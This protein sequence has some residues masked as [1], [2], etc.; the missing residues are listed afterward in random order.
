LDYRKY[1]RYAGLGVIICLAMLSQCLAD[2]V[3]VFNEIMYNPAEDFNDTLEWVELYNQMS[4]NIDLSHWS[5]KGGVKY[6]FPE[7]AIIPADGFVVVALSP[8]DL[9]SRTGYGQAYGPFEGRLSN[10]GEELRLHNNS[11]RMMNSVEYGNEGDWP[12]AADGS[13]VS[14]AKRDPQRGSSA[15][16]NWTWSRQV[17]GTPGRHNFPASQELIEVP[18]LQSGAPARAMVPTNDSLGTT[19]I[20]KDFIDSGWLSGATGVGYEAG[21]GYED[22]IN[23]DVLTQMSGQYPSC[24][25]RVPFYVEDASAVESLSLWMKYDDGF[26][27]Y[28]NGHEVARVN[29]TGLLYWNST[30]DQ[31][32]VEGSAADIDISDYIDSLQDGWNILAIHGLNQAAGSTDFLILPELTAYLSDSADELDRFEGLALNEVASAAAAAGEFQVELYNGGVRTM[33]LAGCV[34]RCAGAVTGEYV[35]GNSSME[36]GDYVVVSEAQLGFRPADEDRLFLYTPDGNSVIDAAVVKNS[37]RGRHPEGSGRWLY[38]DLKTFG[39]ANSFSFHDEIVIN[40]IMYHQRGTAGPNDSYEE[41]RE[42]WLELYNRSDRAVVLTGWEIDGGIEYA[43]PQG[44]TIEPDGYLVVADDATYLR[45]LYPDIDIVGSFSGGLSSR[46]DLIILKDASRNPADE[47]HYYERAPWPEYSDGYGSSLELK[48]PYADNSRPEAWAA[49]DESGKSQWQTVVYRGIA[50]QVY[51]PNPWWSNYHNDYIYW[52]EFRAGLLD[53]GEVLLDDVSVIENPGGAARQLIQNGSF[54]EGRGPYGP[55]HWRIVGNHRHSELI[56]DPDNP[57]NHVLHLKA[58]GRMEPYDNHAETTLKYDGQ[59]IPVEDGKEYEISFRARWLTGSNQLNTRLYFSRLALTTLLEVPAKTGTPGAR[60]SRYEGNIGPTFS[61]FGHS[62]VVPKM[63]QP[64]N[65]SVR[66]SDPDGIN[67]CVLVWRVDGGPW[68]N[69]TMSLDGNGL[70]GA[71]IPGQG[72]STI[73]QFYVA[74]QDGQGT[75][76]YYPSKGHE[77]RALYKVDDGQASSGP[78][79]NLRLILT[80]ADLA[81]MYEPVHVHSDER[82]GATLIYDEREAFYDIGV[83]L[84]GAG[85]SRGVSVGCYNI[86]LDYGH[87]FRDVHRTLKIDRYQGLEEISVKHMFN[88]GRTPCMYD[89][90][91]HFIGPRGDQIGAGIMVM[92]KYEDVFLETQ[93]PNGDKGTAFNLDLT[94]YPIDTQDHG[95]ESLK[96]NAQPQPGLLTQTDLRNLGDDK[97]NYR[98]PLQIKNN[99]RQ[100]DYSGLIAFC[101]TLSLPS[102]ELEA[103]ISKVMDVDEWMRYTAITYLCGIADTYIK[104]LP[105]NMWVYVGLDGKARALPWDMDFTFWHSPTDHPIN[106]LT[107]NN[108]RRV[109][110]L[111]GSRRLYYGHLRDLI[112]TTFNVPYMTYWMQHFDRLL[113]GCNFIADLN[114]I[115]TRSDY[116]L[117][118]LPQIQEAFE[119]R[120]LDPN[121]TVAENYAEITGKAWIDVREIYLQGQP[122]PLELTWTSTSSG[123]TERFYWHTTVPLEPGENVLTFNAYGF[124]GEFIGSDTVTITSTVTEQPLRDYLRLTELMYDPLED[125]DYEFIE[126]LNT[127]PN[128]LDLSEVTISDAVDFSFA[129]SGV[130]SLGPGQYVVIVR[131]LS[132]FSSRYDTSGMLIADGYSGKLANDGERIRIT[133]KWNAEILNFQYS[134]GRLWPLAADGSGHSLVPVETAMA[135][136]PGGLLN[137]PGNWRAS[138]FIHGSPGRADP[139]LPKVVVLNEI[140]A[141]TDSNDPNNGSN[142]WIELY[143]PTT[144]PVTLLAGEWYLSDDR[145][146]LDK[147]AMPHTVIPAKECVSFDEETGFHNPPTVGFGLA[148]AGE[149]V[150]LSYLP[151]SGPQRG[152]IDSVRFEGQESSVSL[153]RYPDAGN[154]WFAMS[155]TRDGNNA[156]PYGHVVIEEI[157]YHPVDPAPE[158]IQLYNPT[159]EAVTLSNDNGGWQLRDGVEYTFDE[160]ISLAPGGRLIVVGFDP[161]VQTEL[162]SFE[163]TYAVR[164]LTAGEDIVGPWTGNLSNGGERLSLEKPQEPDVV[165]QPTIWVIVDEVIYSDRSPWPGDADGTGCPLQRISSEAE[166]AGNDPDNW[167]AA[168][169]ALDKYWV[170]PGDFDNNGVV[171]LRD[172]STLAAAWQSED[173]QGNWNELCDISQSADGVI[174]SRDLSVYAIYW[175]WVSPSSE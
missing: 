108:L 121:Y 69:E 157:M 59:I 81:Y 46:S 4:C 73:V 21:S 34:L 95:L 113:P 8:N 158:Y 72:S 146:Q 14:L 85:Y 114:Y 148:K 117:T 31:P 172:F 19:W 97:E 62:P 90:L 137:Y 80:A 100:D 63:N 66:A 42:A 38:P 169:V 119:V 9:Q 15:P 16:E 101:Q 136:Q 54:E 130:T 94:Y 167:E 154:Y 61:D 171:D 84:K 32:C 133:G 36:P 135:D 60:N 170:A 47:V 30:S 51:G 10:G 106:S 103:Q 12:V 112:N 143:N 87:R 57:N 23:L 153:G 156:E 43:F 93:W 28:I 141:H 68:H 13:G 11:G 138:T 18:V 151:G 107:Y 162:D 159:N 129:G 164:E 175:L 27:A 55:R 26:A 83:R 82:L 98:W 39:S 79:H 104:G 74:A 110:G 45:Q 2:S 99:R 53:S 88:R 96:T 123:S 134:D 3:V 52:N 115:Q 126:L 109:L 65:V 75:A 29:A 173:G 150:V 168:A 125:S 77:S 120:V 71:T 144:N 5:L 111:T 118:Q 174:D 139:T 33:Q 44:T 89:D 6:E 131:N 132:A 92:A 56:V 20:E 40:E 25:I 22:F 102:S 149:E 49:S 128:T 7:G 17:D 161:A 70:Y 165:G 105:H 127:G 1:F 124:D 48:D 78:L 140:M 91:I 145:E 166:A 142:D 147:W 64:V 160:S 24:Y 58:T 67:A 116:V 76:A 35:F 122:E 37:L 41:S 86:K 50:N 163:Q 152:V 155:P